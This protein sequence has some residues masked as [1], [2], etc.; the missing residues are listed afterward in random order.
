[1]EWNG[2][3]WNGMEWNGMEWNGIKECNKL[4]KW[5]LQLPLDK[6]VMHEVSPRK[7]A[8]K[9]RQIHKRNLR[10]M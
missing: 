7:V 10:C 5:F 1:M 8:T 2:M 4:E 9:A 6:L 3:E